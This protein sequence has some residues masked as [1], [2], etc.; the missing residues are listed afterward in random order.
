MKARGGD[1]VALLVLCAWIEPDA[2]DAG[3]RIRITA[4]ARDPTG[5][6]DI[7]RVVPD[8]DRACAEVRAWLTR[9]TG[10][11]DELPG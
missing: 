8:V 3:L 5:E 10:P 2:Q 11:S 6:H 7:A 1:R 9:F 4:V